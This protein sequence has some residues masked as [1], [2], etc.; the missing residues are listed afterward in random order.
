MEEDKYFLS[1]SKD[2]LAHLPQAHYEGN[3]IVVDKPEEVEVAISALRHYKVIG[4]DT[5]T[6]PSF[7][8]GQSN[9]VALMQISAGDTCYLF[10]LNTLGFIIPLR[11][12]L[13]DEHITKIGASVHDDF[14]NLR[15]LAQFTP[16]GFIDVQQYVKQFHIVD[17]SLSRIYG[18]IFGQRISKNQRLSNWESPSLTNSQQAY[19]SLDAYACTRIYEELSIGKFEPT[20]SVYKHY[21]ELVI[22]A[23]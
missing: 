5:E 16:A 7:K 1:I 8:R 4:F 17:N 11:E 23:D 20:T 18:I 19:A 10:R 3:I 6:K 12:L 21:P 13:E 15:K 2:E 9:N 14:L 22:P